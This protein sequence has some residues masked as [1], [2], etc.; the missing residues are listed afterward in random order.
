MDKFFLG[1]IKSPEDKRDYV[2]QA[3]APMAYK[4]VMLSPLP[5]I[6]NQG[7]VGSCVA[8]EC[9]YIAEYY[10]GEVCSTAFIYGLRFNGYW[11]GVGM[12]HRDALNTMLNY[13][14]CSE[15]E[16]PG[17][18]EMQE[19]KNYVMGKVDSGTWLPF[20]FK[21]DEP[22]NWTDTLRAY[23]EKARPRKIMSYASVT[24][25]DG[26]KAALANGWPVIFTTG[27]NNYYPDAK[28]HIFKPN[29]SNAGFHSMSVWGWDYLD[30]K[31]YFRVSNSWGTSWGDGGFCW[32]SAE[33]ILREQDAW[34]VSDMKEHKD[35]RRTLKLVP[36]PRMIGEDVKL[37]QTLLNKHGAK[38][39]TDGIFGPATDTAVKAFQAAHGMTADGVIG[40]DTWNA[41]EADPIEPEPTPEPDYDNDLIKECTA[42]LYSQLGQ[43]Y[44]WGGDGDR[45]ITE[46]VIRKME[47]STRNADRTVA[48]WKQMI[49]DGII[50]IKGYDC[51]G[52]ISRFLEDKDIVVGKRNANHLW[53]MCTPIDKSELREGDLLFRQTEGDNYHVGYYV[54]GGRVIEAKGRDDGV[55]IRGV[56]AQLGY[57]THYGRLK[58]FEVNK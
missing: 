39:E 22:D 9:S 23:V 21:T 45:E 10:T 25:A 2:V 42:F 40:Q 47:N 51:S 54:G 8:H 46:A 4:P 35:I 34:A 29:G 30:G 48:Y 7:S 15:A 27:I 56:N 24:T 11:S 53:N 44:V 31:E 55:V 16:C 28:T 52:L 5:K 26:L 38:L 37:A 32:M 17:N 1:A 58:V 36:K 14:E 3:V 43:L 12:Y 18:I 19:A 50:D 6:K 33:D 13:G 41:L 20:G 49:A 57:W